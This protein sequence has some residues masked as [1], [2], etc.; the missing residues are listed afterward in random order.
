MTNLPVLPRQARLD[1]PDTFHP[2]MV[3]GLECRVIFKEDT[4]RQDFVAPL[5]RLADRRAPTVDAWTLLP[6]YAHLLVC[7][8]QRPLSRRMRNLLTEYAG[9]VH[10]TSSNSRASST[11]IRSAPRSPISGAWGCIRGPFH[12]AFATRLTGVGRRPPGAGRPES[13]PAQSEKPWGTSRK[14]FANWLANVW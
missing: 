14:A 2:V 13:E 5:A 3:R 9:T 10:R 8:G 12:V 7:T 11:A 1:A 4:D 6:N